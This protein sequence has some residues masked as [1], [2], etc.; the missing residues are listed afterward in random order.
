VQ[1]LEVV[2]KK[3]GVY[4]FFMI[5]KE[6]IQ[7]R[8]T[9][10]PISEEEV[11]RQIDKVKKYVQ[12]HQNEL[13][14]AL[15]EAMDGFSRTLLA[16]K[17]NQPQPTTDGTSQ[18][19]QEQQEILKE[20]LPLAIQK[21]G[22]LQAGDLK[23]GPESELVK[24]ALPMDF[25]LDK[26]A[27]QVKH[28]LA[29]I[30]Q[31]N[32]ELASIIGPVAMIKQVY[33]TGDVHVGPFYP[34]LPVPVAIP[35]NAILVLI[36]A[37]LESCRLLVS[38]SMLDVP[39]LRQILSL[40]LAIYDVLRGQWRDGVLTMMGFFSESWVLY[41]V[42]GKTTRWIYNF[43]APDIQQ[44]IESDM[45]AGFKSM[46]L[47]YWL[48]V[49]SIVSPDYVRLAIQNLIDTAKRPLEEVNQTLAT[50]EAQAQKSAATIGA[51]VTFPRL[52]LD[53]LP[54]FDDIQNFQ[55]LLHQPELYCS[56][57]FQTALAPAMV[58]PVLRLVFELMDIP[59]NSDSLAKACEGQPATLVEAI[60]ESLA[61]TVTMP[62]IPMPSLNPP[63]IQEQKGGRKTRSKRSKRRVTKRKR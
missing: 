7:N 61:P 1:R 33:P 42:I 12:T 59:T 31:K 62:Q 43:I 34:Y 30:D 60:T 10:S 36:N 63:I 16:H 20:A 3:H 46:M 5:N 23:F 25:S 14:K 48:W 11:L 37:V 29:S 4:V 49:A 40:V 6:Y 44:R 9:P 26:I 50:L 54:S 58:I 17:N 22:A 47:G 57:A 38:S 56:P 2:Y 51:Q 52:P 45:Y 41:G 27:E 53:K 39:I 18:W 15:Y 28:Y 55:T 32:R 8:M 24:S 19:T 35:T 13:P 21:G